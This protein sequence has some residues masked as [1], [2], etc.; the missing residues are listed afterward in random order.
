MTTFYLKEIKRYNFKDYIFYLVYNEYKYTIMLDVETK[1]SHIKYYINDVFIESFDNNSYY[2]LPEMSNYSISNEVY[3]M[4]IFDCGWSY[5]Y[6]LNSYFSKS[7]LY[8][9]IIKPLLDSVILKKRLYEFFIFKLLLKGKL[10]NDAYQYT[11]RF[12]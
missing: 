6:S 8:V 3:D 5:G 9:N 7:R 4:S 11:I 2:K 10:T 12:L 1:I